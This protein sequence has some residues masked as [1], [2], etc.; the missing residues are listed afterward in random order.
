MA[1]VTNCTSLSVEFL[2]IKELSVVNP[3]DKNIAYPPG[4]ISYLESL[5]NHYFQKCRWLVGDMFVSSHEGFVHT[6]L[7]ALVT[8]LYDPTWMSQ[9]VRIN[10]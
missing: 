10:G 8:S 3:Y 9:E 2:G 5:E 7:L 6:N 4:S 1:E